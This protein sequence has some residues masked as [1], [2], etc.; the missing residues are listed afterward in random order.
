MVNQQRLVGRSGTAFSIT[1]GRGARMGLEAF[2][3]SR[4][5]EVRVVEHDEASFQ[6]Y[7]ER[8]VLREH[9][10]GRPLKEILEDPYIRGWSTPYERARLLERPRIVEAIGEHAVADLRRTVAASGS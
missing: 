3:D 8:Y 7:L 6:Q 1:A 10:R 2:V 5:L 4:G 9:K